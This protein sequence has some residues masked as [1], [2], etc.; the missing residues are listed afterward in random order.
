MQQLITPKAIARDLDIE[1]NWCRR[2]IRRKYKRRPGH[3]WGWTPE[4]AAEVKKYVEK[5]INGGGK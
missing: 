1:P 2:L 3:P 5:A 4:E